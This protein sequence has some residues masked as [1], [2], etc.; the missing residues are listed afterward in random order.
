VRDER[1][2][3]VFYVGDFD[4][5]G[6]HMSEVDLPTRLSRYGAE[7]LLLLQRVALTA[8]DCT[9]DLPSFEAGTK[10]KDPR[11]HWFLHRVRRHLLGA[12]RPRSEGA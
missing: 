10:D 4:P 8:E 12:G 7:E 2:L 11:Y 9:S 6:M 5:S 1:Q 3:Q